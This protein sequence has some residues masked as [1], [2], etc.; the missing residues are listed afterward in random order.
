MLMLSCALVAHSFLGQIEALEPKESL[1]AIEPAEPQLV[2]KPAEPAPTA[3]VVKPVPPKSMDNPKYAPGSNAFVNATSLALRTGPNTSAALIHYIK[4]DEVVTVLKDVVPPVPLTIGG[5][6]GFW[7]YIQHKNHKGYVF[8][9]FLAGAPPS[10]K[11]SLDLVCVPGKKVGGITAKTTYQDLARMVG[12]VNLGMARIPLEEKGKFEEAT[13]VFPGDKHKEL[14]IQW[15]V[16]RVSPKAVIVNGRNWKTASGIGIGTRLDDIL[17]KNEVPI[18]FLGFGHEYA[19]FVT[20]WGGGKLESTHPLRKSM[21]LYLS[22]E[23]PYT[24]ENYASVQGEGEFSSVLD[25]VKELNLKVSSMI[26]MLK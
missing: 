9:A 1:P 22:P 16:L 18:S 15:D 10:L 7:I 2:E 25:P 24:S 19:G 6:S 21:L 14:I 8:D 12:E 5:K 17:T 23:K 3:P 11:D 13:A 20:S 26:I 4:K